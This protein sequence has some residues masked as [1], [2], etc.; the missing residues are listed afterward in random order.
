MNNE[1]ILLRKLCKSYYLI[2]Q[3][4]KAWL[5]IKQFQTMS[6]YF[7]FKPLVDQGLL[8]EVLQ[9]WDVN[10][11]NRWHSFF[12]LLNGIVSFIPAYFIKTPNKIQRMSYISRPIKLPFQTKYV[13]L[14]RFTKHKC[15]VICPLM[16]S[17][18]DR[19]NGFVKVKSDLNCWWINS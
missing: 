4:S 18:S 8:T 11:G 13:W 10:S 7:P 2:I 15:V 6:P 1:I 14:L 3:I 5:P 17:Q 9:Q 12:S 19:P 16:A